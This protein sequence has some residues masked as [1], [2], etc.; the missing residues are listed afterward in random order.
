MEA[1]IVPLFEIEKEVFMGFPGNGFPLEVQLILKGILSYEDHNFEEDTKSL[2]LGR[3]LLSVILVIRSC[4]IKRYI[5]LN[6]H[7]QHCLDD[8]SG[9]LCQTRS[10]WIS[11][12]HMA[13]FILNHLG[14][15]SESLA[16]EIG[17]ERQ[18]HGNS[19]MAKE[20]RVQ[21]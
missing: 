19:L 17:R 3:R 6:P 4:N 12:D 16:F 21:G 15:T 14:H 18:F 9:T 2:R 5:F 7:L 13:R 11:R 1:G 10:K 8:L 20:Q